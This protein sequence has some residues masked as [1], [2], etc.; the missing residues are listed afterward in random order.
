[1]KEC[2]SIH[3]ILSKCKLLF[4]SILNIV[5]CSF[6]TDT[7][8]ATKR[9]SEALQRVSAKGTYLSWADDVPQGS[10][11]ELIWKKGRCNFRML[12]PKSR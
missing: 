6:Y 7:K 12:Y 5:R 11:M 3:E 1:M 9:L 2:S 8:S 4:I 10:M